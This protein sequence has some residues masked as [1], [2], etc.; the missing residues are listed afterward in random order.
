MR[1]VLKIVSY[2]PTVVSTTKMQERRRQNR[3]WNLLWL[4]LFIFGMQLFQGG[5]CLKN[6]EMTLANWGLKQLFRFSHEKFHCFDVLT[7]RRTTKTTN[8][9][10]STLK[11][12]LGKIQVITQDFK[13]CYIRY[14]LIPYVSRT[15]RFATD[16]DNDKHC[17]ITSWATIY[18]FDVNVLY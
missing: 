17:I 5:V 3:Q 4:L 18:L 10:I 16:Y 15:Y 8:A 1:F 6:F 14:R 2:V 9:E 11:V 13:I 12:Y 7:V